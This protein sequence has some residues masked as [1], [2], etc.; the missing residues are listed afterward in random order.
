MK[1]TEQILK[2]LTFGLLGGALI[3][4]FI[5]SCW[6]YYFADCVTLKEQAPMMAAPA[7]CINE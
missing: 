4:M 7:R 5:Y 3:Y 2:Y 1:K 6:A